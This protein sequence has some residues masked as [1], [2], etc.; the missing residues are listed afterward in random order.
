[1]HRPHLVHHLELLPGCP[2]TVW[3][4][5]QSPVLREVHKLC[6]CHLFSSSCSCC[7]P[8]RRSYSLDTQHTSCLSLGAVALCP[9]AME[10]LCAESPALS[11][12]HELC[13]RHL[14]SCSCACSCCPP[15]WRSGRR[16]WTA[17]LMNNTWSCCSCC[18]PQCGVTSPA[19]VYGWCACRLFNRSCSCCHPC[20]RS[21]SLDT[22]HT[23]CTTPGAV[24]GV[25]NHSGITVTS[26]E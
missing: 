17:H 25:S 20:R 13:A 26:P 22:Q 11:E 5:S 14:L 24:A 12:E 6:A 7:H 23:S 8:R 9:A 18:Q 10:G 16:E 19:E 1:M 15:C 21:L 3:L 4:S 2:T